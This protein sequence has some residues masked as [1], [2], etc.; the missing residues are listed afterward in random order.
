MRRI[1]TITAIAILVCGCAREEDPKETLAAIPS[2]VIVMWSGTIASIPEG[3]ALCD[4]SSGT[5]DLRDRFIYG[6][7]AGEDPGATGGAST[8][9][10]TVDQMPSYL[11][12]GTIPSS[13]TNVKGPAVLFRGEVRAGHWAF[14]GIGLREFKPHEQ[15]L[16]PVPLYLDSAVGGGATIDNRPAYFKLAFIMKL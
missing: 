11:Q 1:A 12:T 8:Y 6:I 5:P 13:L 14:G 4:G 2:G 15:L 9:S 10:L 7:G 3:W 16:F